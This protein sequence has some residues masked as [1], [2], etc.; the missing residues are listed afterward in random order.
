MRTNLGLMLTAFSVGRTRLDL[1]LRVGSGRLLAAPRTLGHRRPRPGAAR[2]MPPAMG[3]GDATTTT[4]KEK[5]SEAYYSLRRQLA[6][7]STQVDDSE[8]MLGGAEELNRLERAVA[9]LETEMS[10]EGFWDDNAAATA[11]LREITR[12]K[13]TLGRL[14]RWRDVL[15]DSEIALEIAADALD[16]GLGEEESA[17]LEESTQ[18]LDGLKADLERWRLELLLSGPYDAEG[19]RVTV[20]AGAGGT[21]AQDWAEMLVRMYTRFGEQRG[22]SVRSV[23]VSDGDEAG[24]RS[25]TL[26]VSSEEKAEVAEEAEE[27]K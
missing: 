20:I 16:D 14:S 19:G 1:G 4:T 17:L 6:T 15:S 24:I 10:Q 2:G 21:D 9:D 25:A 13:D 12:K 5:T 11:T 27:A 8:A 26:E 18:A 3:A 7:V 22:F 23:E